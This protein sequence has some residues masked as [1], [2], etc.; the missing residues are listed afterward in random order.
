[1][2][3]AQKIELTK[4][5]AAIRKHV[6]EMLLHC[7]YGHVGG[8]MS[9]V[10]TLAVLY[11]GQLRYDAANPQWEG[12]DYLVLSK[13][14]SGPGLYAALAQAGFFDSALL[15]TLNQG[16]SKLPSHPDRL[17]TPGIDATTGSLGQGAS[18]AAG[19]GMAL[20]LKKADQYVFL[21]V[22]DGELNEGQCWEAFQLIPGKGLDNVVVYID[23]NKRQL[24]G[25]TNDIMPQYDLTAK[26]AAFGFHA[27]SVPGADLEAIWSATVRAKQRK[28]KPTR[29]VLDSVK[30]Q[31]I[32]YFEKMVNNHSVKFSEQDRQAAAEAL[33]RLEQCFLTRAK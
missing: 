7:G 20:K 29:I 32:E 13:G 24:D 33:A 11:G 10:E 23:E 8:S 25:Y 3:D 28:G 12:R 16:G 18:V 4:R 1:M 15:N 17:K 19:I 2:D 26:M 5:A 9:I 22:G 21:I 30:G 31:G 14:H 6:L 27:E